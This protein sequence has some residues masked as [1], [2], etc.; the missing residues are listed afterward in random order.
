MAIFPI[1]F[2]LSHNSCA[3]AVFY[4]RILIILFATWINT[5]VAEQAVSNSL[6]QKISSSEYWRKLL[7]YRYS[8]LRFSNISEITDDRFFL[9]DRGRSDPAQEL[10]ATISA[11]KADNNSVCRFPARY[12]WLSEKYGPELGLEQHK[13][14]NCNDLMNWLNT[15]NPGSATLVFP[16]AYLNSPS[17]MF[18]HTLLRIDP[19]DD[20]A[21]LPLI[22]YAINYAANVVQKDNNFFFAFK[23]IFG[24][25]NGVM[26][27]VPYHE[28][29]TEY[30]DIEN[31]DIWEYKLK[32]SREDVLQLLRHTWE[33]KELDSAY[34]FFTLNCSYLILT[35]LEATKEGVNL[36]GQFRFKAIP[37]DTVRAVTDANLVD[38]MIFRPS[39]ATLL[40]QRYSLLN[41]TQKSRVIDIVKNKPVL[42][43]NYFNETDESTQAKILELSYD[44]L[45][46]EANQ[47]PARR[48]PFAEYSH[49]LLQ[50]RSTKTATGLWPDSERPNVRPE[51]GHE[52]SRLMIGY[53]GV[54]VADE[55]ENYTAVKIR[56]AYHDLLDPSAGFPIGAQINFLDVSASYDTDNGTSRI[57]EITF[58][59]IMSLTPQHELFNPLSWHV[60][61]SFEKLRSFQESF[62]I[63]QVTSGA[64]KALQ[65]APSFLIYSFANGSLEYSPDYD[66]N[67]ALGA[68]FQLGALISDSH[69]SSKLE[70][71]SGRYFSGQTDTRFDAVAALAFHLG[72]SSSLRIEY[73]RTKLFETYLNQ[74]Q[75]SLHWYY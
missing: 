51:Q 40:S 12:H 46:Y 22:S 48:D 50:M 31:R 21:N 24:G 71:I 42:D 23:G 75:I 13:L 54:E 55:S 6:V 4:A 11:F 44:A 26:A 32:F 69:Y 38:D 60:D 14:K 20:R 10:L 62:D 49:K 58:I 15:I 66:D 19:A 72:K 61:F 1:I 68:E 7:H 2:R 25:Y 33:M 45:R 16:A 3:S 56:P 64:G 28:K 8:Y 43:Q 9:S 35:L 67:Y 74:Q 70:V 5:A 39:A 29:I 37:V 30:G 41:D 27:I 57:D 47:T 53:R 73:Q 18:G 36:T 17:S 65:A 52:S 34:Y 59:D 63:L